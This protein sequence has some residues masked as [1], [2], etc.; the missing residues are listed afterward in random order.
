MFRAI[1]SS[2]SA[3]TKIEDADANDNQAKSGVFPIRRGVLQGGITSPLFFIVALE[4]I[5]SENS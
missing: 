4:L 2:A 1:Y 5:L 3:L